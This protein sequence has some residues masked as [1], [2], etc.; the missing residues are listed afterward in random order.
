M[1]TLPESGRAVHLRLRSTPGTGLAARR[2]S[3]AIHGLPEPPPQGATGNQRSEYAPLTPDAHFTALQSNASNL[4]TGDTNGVKDMFVLDRVAGIT[5]RISVS[6]A[7]IQANEDCLVSWISADGRFVAF[8]SRS[9]NLV[10]GKTNHAEDVF[11]HDRATGATERVS[12]DAYGGE[13]NFGSDLSD[14]RFVTFFN[15]ASNLVPGDSND[16]LAGR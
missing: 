6:S 2:G 5:T 12:M 8:L 7:G 13:A 14:G 4:V 1:D 16:V 15:L 9:V 11:I 10:A 3:G